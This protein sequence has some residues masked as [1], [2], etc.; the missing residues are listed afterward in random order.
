LARESPL[1]LATE[2]LPALDKTHPVHIKHTKKLLTENII[3]FC[4]LLWKL[5]KLFN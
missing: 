2:S 4:F 3:S 1:M 5:E